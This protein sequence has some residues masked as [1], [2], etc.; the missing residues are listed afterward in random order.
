MKLQSIS[1]R[2]PP[3]SSSNL[4]TTIHHA[5]IRHLLLHPIPY[6][7]PS[8]STGFTRLLFHLIYGFL[9]L[10]T[11][12]DHAPTLRL[13]VG[14]T[15][16]FGAEGLIEGVL[17]DH[18]LDGGFVG[19]G[20]FEEWEGEHGGG[21]VGEGFVLCEAKGGIEGE[22]AGEVSD[23]EV[24]EDGLLVAGHVDGRWCLML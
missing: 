16:A 23:G 6:P 3:A 15:H 4:R 9:A 2:P 20:V 21:F 22:G 13:S 7:N 5:L 10:P 1:Q 14:N 18:D 19:V 8:L 11:K 17:E 24:D 12:G